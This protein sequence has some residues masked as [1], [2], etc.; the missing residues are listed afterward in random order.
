MAKRTLSLKIETTG[1]LQNGK[2]AGPGLSPGSGSAG[3][4]RSAA[5]QEVNVRIC[6]TYLLY[7]KE[8]NDLSLNTGSP[9]TVVL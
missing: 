7:V 1:P 5:D 2:G 6:I 4:G 8:F 9:K 3:G